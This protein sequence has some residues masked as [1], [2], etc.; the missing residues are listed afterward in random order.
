MKQK[1]EPKNEEI[2]NTK[3]TAPCPP[4]ANISKRSKLFEISDKAL[5]ALFPAQQLSNQ[6]LLFLCRSPNNLPGRAG[7]RGRGIAAVAAGRRGGAGGGGTRVGA[8]FGSGGFG[9]KIEI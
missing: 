7:T 6:T 1:S 2:R 9:D 8:R 4:L 5:D 3:I